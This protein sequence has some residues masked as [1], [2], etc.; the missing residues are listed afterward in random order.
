M[1]SEEISSL[2]NKSQR[3]LAAAKLLYSN[4]DYDF[5]VS[6]SYYAMFY[7]IEALLLSL[8]LSFSKHSGAISAFGK[9][10]IKTKKMP[11]HLHSFINNAFKDRQISDYESIIF[12]QQTE[13]KLHIENALIFVDETINYFNK[14]N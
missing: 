6:R 2:L 9:E 10:F 4:G 5:S 3:S 13:A 14:L 11:E 1:K 12:I 7:C 8:G